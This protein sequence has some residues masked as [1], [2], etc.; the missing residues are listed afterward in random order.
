MKDF[1]EQ[2][3]KIFRR[4]RQ[5]FRRAVL[6]SSR[7]AASSDDAKKAIGRICARAVHLGWLELPK[8]SGKSHP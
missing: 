5:A 3:M 4:L 6:I 1:T 7:R 8:L 2:E